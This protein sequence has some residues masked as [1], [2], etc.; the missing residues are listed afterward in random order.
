MGITGSQTGTFAGQL[1]DSTAV[2]VKFTWGGDANVD[3]KL[4]IDDYGRIDSNVAI[5][6]ASGW[7]NGDF[8]YDGKIKMDDYGIIDSNIAAGPPLSAAGPATAAAP[9]RLWAIDA[10]LMIDGRR[11]TL[12]VGHD[13]SAA[14][15]DGSRPRY[16]HRIAVGF[17]A[18]RRSA[19]QRGTDFVLLFTLAR[20]FGPRR[21]LAGVVTAAWSASDGHR[22]DARGA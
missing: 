4:N 8:N 2:L 17:A 3:G 15:V 13:I 9:K 20:S 18:P 11:R 16:P 21:L 19:G 6:G 7:Y 22:S 1:I 14:L 10:P 12:T 5:P